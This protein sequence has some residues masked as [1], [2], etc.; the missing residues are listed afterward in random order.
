MFLK[1]EYQPEIFNFNIL[2]ILNWDLR[3]HIQIKT[4]PKFTSGIQIIHVRLIS[5][6]RPKNVKSLKKYCYV[7]ECIFN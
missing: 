7:E 4:K 6:L 1:N 5:F 3:L 2:Q